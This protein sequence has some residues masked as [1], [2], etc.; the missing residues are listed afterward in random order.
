MAQRLQAVLDGKNA[1][2]GGIP[3]C[4]PQFGAGPVGPYVCPKGHGFARISPWE[5]VAS[6]DGHNCTATFSLRDSSD[7][8]AVFPHAFELECVA[9]IYPQSEV[10][11][12]VMS[13]DSPHLLHGHRARVRARGRSLRSA[14]RSTPP[15]YLLSRVAARIVRKALPRT[16]GVLIAN[17]D[18]AP[19]YCRRYVVTLAADGSLATALKVCNTGQTPMPFQ[20]LLH[21]YFAADAT[22]ACVQVTQRL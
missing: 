8:R 4:W 11:R 18:T 15:P 5:C 1:I 2:R 7:T 19:G 13:E 12:A 21:T 20:A 6:T 3:V 22:T 10:I 14:L 9:C 17:A 16:G